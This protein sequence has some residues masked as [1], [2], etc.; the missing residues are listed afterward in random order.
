MQNWPHS[1]SAPAPFQSLELV[2]TAAYD[3]AALAALMAKAHR[4]AAHRGGGSGSATYTHAPSLQ[5]AENPEWRVWW[6]PPSHWRDDL[7]WSSGDT[8][9]CIVRPDATMA[10][11]SGQRTLYTTEASPADW[12]VST[13]PSGIVDL[14]TIRSRFAAFPLIV[15]PLPPSEW[16]FEE[17]SPEE[18]FDRWTARR[19]R[20]SRLPG[21]ALPAGLPRSGCWPGV[22][23]Y[24]CLL[25][26][27]LGILV[28]LTGVSNGR[29]VASLAVKTMIVDADIP[30]A[31]FSFT[32]PAGTI[33]VR[34]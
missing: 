1:V 9:V 16:T 14:P 25:V 23:E 6:R 30:D 28:E 24:E 26:D 19:I 31:M 8:T 17:F 34:A 15:P 12:P 21:T 13:R 7:A 18:M 20:A 10:Y 3:H 5:A 2:A 29:R 33:V 22:D 11:V 32:P 4:S 27:A